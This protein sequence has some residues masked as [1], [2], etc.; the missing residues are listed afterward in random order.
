MSLA[1]AGV[2]GEYASHTAYHVPTQTRRWMLLMTY[3]FAFPLD[4]ALQSSIDEI[5]AGQAVGRFPDP[6]TSVA[7]AIGTNDG[8]V[9]A[10]AEDVIQIL[11]H[12][13]EGAGVLDVLAK[14]LKGTMHVLIRQ[15]MGKV[16]HKEQERLAGYLRNRRIVINGETRFG[17]VMPAALGE[18]LEGILENIDHGRM[19]HVRAE[20]TAAMLEFVDHAVKSFYEDFT[21]CLELGMIKRKMVDI[22]HGTVLKGSHS[23]VKKLFTTMSDDD[24]KRVAQHYRTMF[25]FD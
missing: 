6:S 5:L 13:G 8:I 7:V 16:D 20:L 23:A 15:I 19:E 24:L 11:K 12:N 14:L 25:V 9:K 21:Q 3:Y 10:T 2:D 17:F 4:A 22:G 18:T 1:K